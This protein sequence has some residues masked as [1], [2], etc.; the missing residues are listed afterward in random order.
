MIIANDYKTIEEKVYEAMGIKTFKKIVLNM[1]QKLRK[2]L[3]INDK[4]ISGDNYFIESQNLEGYN[5]F[6]RHGLLYNFSVHFS[7]MII[8]GLLIVN[9]LTSS[10]INIGLL[11]IDGL[12]FGINTYCCMLQRYNQIR[13]NKVIDRLK[14]RE[15]KKQIKKDDFDK[16]KIIN[17][18]LNLNQGKNKVEIEELL[19]KKEKLIIYKNNKSEEYNASNV[20]INNFQKRKTL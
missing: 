18:T 7:V 8:G 19:Q 4:K 20:G 13:I 16:E 5:K 10:N 11:A 17:N 2:S 14:I 1:Q 12:F 9:K 6:K 3:K 15:Q